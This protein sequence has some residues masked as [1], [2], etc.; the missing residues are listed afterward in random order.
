[1]TVCPKMLNFLTKVKR[2]GSFH[3]DLPLSVCPKNFNLFQVEAFVC[4][5][6]LL[7]TLSGVMTT[8]L[9]VWYFFHPDRL[10]CRTILSSNKCNFQHDPTRISV[11][12][13][14]LNIIKT[15]VNDNRSLWLILL[16]TFHLY[17][18]VKK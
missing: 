16:S 4:Y 13:S 7:P 1:M 15:F 11:I 2:W 8:I 3:L 14:L 10:C 5:V 12:L 17:I 6:Y 18:Q 9:C